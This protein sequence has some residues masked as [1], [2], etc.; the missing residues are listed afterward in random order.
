[1]KALKVQGQNYLHSVIANN[2][3]EI[4]QYL[5][6]PVENHS[7]DPLQWWKSHVPQFPKLS[8]VAKEIL[9]IPGSAV[10]VERVFNVGSDVIGIRR[11]ALNEATISILMFGNHFLK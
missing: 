11:H 10:S 7:I 6:L 1:M 9:S 8:I 2:K 4:E 5:N 3:P